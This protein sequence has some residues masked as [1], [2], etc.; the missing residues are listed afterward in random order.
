MCEFVE[1][2]ALVYSE[3]HQQG[4]GAV[5][6]ADIIR[7]E[8]IQLLFAC[9]PLPFSQIEKKVNKWL[10]KQPD[11][12]AILKEV[13]EV[14]YVS[15][16]PQMCTHSLTNYT[17]PSRSRTSPCAGR[18]TTKATWCFR[19]KGSCKGSTTTCFITSLQRIARPQSCGPAPWRQHQAS[20]TALPRLPRPTQHSSP[21]RH[22]PRRGRCLQSSTQS[23]AALPVDGA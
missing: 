1:N 17:Q 10:S 6:L 22:S 14:K 5:S 18:P 15:I 19:S 4:V 13:S 8:I 2:L 21:S 12:D 7:Y 11:F 3:R 20:S 16:Q 23:S 9:G